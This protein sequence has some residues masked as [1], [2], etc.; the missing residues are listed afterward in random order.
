[1]PDSLI[2]LE[3]DKIKPLRFN[4]SHYCKHSSQLPVA[5]HHSEFFVF[6]GKMLLSKKI[7][8]QRPIARLLVSKKGIKFL[9]FLIIGKKNRK[10]FR[11]RLKDHARHNRILMIDDTGKRQFIRQYPGLKVNFLGQ[12]N[13]VIL[14]HPVCFSDSRF[15][16]YDASK[17]IIKSSHY[18][19]H[20]NCDIGLKNTI[21]I[22]ENFS[23]SDT[24]IHMPEE[25]NLHVK[26]G[27]DCM[28]SWDVILWP[29]DTHTIYDNRTKK[30]L[31]R[32]QKGIIIGNHV[33]LGHGVHILKDA[34]VSDYCMVGM[35]SLVTKKFS[36][37]NC[38]IVGQPAK[39]I[40][41]GINWDRKNT[42][43]YENAINTN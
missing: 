16:M 15:D 27:D 17:V 39:I 38:I 21:E 29:T 32:P 26:I 10:K 3:G 35:H 2:G 13:L 24:L 11:M 22:G 41:T 19:I 28:F 33:W 25:P 34:I 23:S 31:N 42:F 30:I 1:M 12:N 6:G 37:P 36:Q 14:Y 8:I 5:V 7:Y 40:Q 43:E 4:I 20:L 9:S 18:R